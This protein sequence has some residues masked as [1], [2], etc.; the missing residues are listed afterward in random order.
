MLGRLIV[1]A[2][3]AIG[4]LGELM[5]ISTTAQSLG[6]TSQDAPNT[7][8][9]QYPNAPTGVLNGTT[10]IIPIPLSLARTLI[11]SNLN[12]LEHAYRALMPTFESG[13]YPLVLQG[14]HDHDIQLLAYN[15]TVP[16]FLVCIIPGC[17]R[18]LFGLFG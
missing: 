17:S 16:D 13:M 10:V 11:P 3:L 2:M 7:I 4:L 12:I 9:S 14:L 15:I 18:L 6:C 8:A 1:R 5:F